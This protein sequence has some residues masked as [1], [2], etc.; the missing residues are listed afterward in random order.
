M[1]W[2]YNINILCTELLSQ[3]SC[4]TYTYTLERANLSKALSWYSSVTL[5]WTM[6]V[7]SKSFA[8]THM[9][10]AQ[11]QF[12]MCHGFTLLADLELPRPVGLLPYCETY[13][14]NYSLCTVFSSYYQYRV[15][16]HIIESLTPCLGNG[17]TPRARAAPKWPAK[18][19]A[20]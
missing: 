4:Y 19:R 15:I 6:L 14:Y 17:S 11:P 10:V 8:M 18:H 5:M 9:S 7:R 12:A 13:T 16:T 3:K 1:C 2:K 20:Y